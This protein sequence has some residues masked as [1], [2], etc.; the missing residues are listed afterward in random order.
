MRT[1]MGLWLLWL[2]KV[3][4]EV[5]KGRGVERKKEGMGKGKGEE[6]EAELVIDT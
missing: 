2:M 6:G 3:W 4:I 1:R 5:R